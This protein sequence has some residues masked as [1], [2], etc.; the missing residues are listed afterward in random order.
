MTGPVTATAPVERSLL[1]VKPDGVAR[2]QV[3]EVLRRVETK[4]YRLA[5]LDL[6]RPD[7]ETLREHYVDHLDK[8]FYPELEAFMTSGP[9][10]VAIVEGVRVVE[11]LMALCGP[12]DPTKAPPGTI[13]GDLGCDV[14][15][16]PTENVVH[17]SDCPEAAEREI[18]IWFGSSTRG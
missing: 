4:G 1:I 5:A 14:G 8:P 10:V 7:R 2:G 6:R 17:R 13:R 11:G 9:V 18:K 15:H 16:G 12:T 3:G